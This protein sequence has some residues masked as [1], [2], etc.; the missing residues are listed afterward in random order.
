MPIAAGDAHTCAL[1][2]KG[3]A[4][5]WGW[6]H[7]GQLGDGTQ[8]DHAAPTPVVGLA[9]GIV[10]LAAGILHT[11]ALDAQGGVTCWGDG[12]AGQL[13]D[14]MP[15][16]VTRSSAVPVA[17]PG[18]ETG[19]VAIAAATYTTCAALAA[20]PV[21][22]WGPEGLGTGV[23]GQAS[24]V[25]VAVAG[26]DG[27]VLSLRA[28]SGFFCGVTTA[29]LRCWGSTLWGAFGDGMAPDDNI[30]ARPAATSIGP[31]FG[32]SA[33]ER[34]LCAVAANGSVLC[35]GDGSL[36]GLGAP[37]LAP[38][39]FASGTPSA[40]WGLGSGVL[41]I[42]TGSQALHTCAWTTSTLWCWG[43]NSEGQVGAPTTDAA[44]DIVATPVAVPM[45]SGPFSAVATG[46]EHTCA[47]ANGHIFCW[48]SNEVGQLGVGLVSDGSSL[49]VEV[50]GR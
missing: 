38:D 39:A 45:L 17:I 16:G 42:S 18:L 8:I 1:D 13:A 5:C 29:G 3:G 12:T 34:N 19:V 24:S 30:S 44:L 14:G 35:W 50:S 41:G 22:C 23:A 21:M 37:D 26:L 27:P 4:T 47:V 6:N 46:D 15:V 33:S 28:G 43:Y 49:P 11:C 25:P 36:G 31:A 10:A 40:V 9:S 32:W 2:T 48:G 7:A 20:G